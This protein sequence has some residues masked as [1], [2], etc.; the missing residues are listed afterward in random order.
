MTGEIFS[1]LLPYRVGAQLEIL[2]IVW[3]VWA[4]NEYIIAYGK[5]NY[6]KVASYEITLY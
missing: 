5:L 1:I 2:H 6:P 3:S 4:M